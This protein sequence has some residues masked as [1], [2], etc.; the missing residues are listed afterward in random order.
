[1]D[2]HDC[3]QSHGEVDEERDAVAISRGPLVFEQQ[4]RVRAPEPERDA[5]PCYKRF[6]ASHPATLI[7][8][9]IGVSST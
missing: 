3:E 8:I 1:M 4:E 2:D 9:Q 6:A 5:T 7:P